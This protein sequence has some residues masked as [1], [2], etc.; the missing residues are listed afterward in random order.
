MA[1]SRL[2]DEQIEYIKRMSS[3]GDFYIDC[4]LDV[5]DGQALLSDILE[6]IKAQDATMKQLRELLSQAHDLTDPK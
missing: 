2:S 5:D 4:L 1:T 6:H 3:D